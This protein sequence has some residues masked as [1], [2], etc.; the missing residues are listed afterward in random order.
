[1]SLTSTLIP[2]RVLSM[3][4]TIECQGRQDI[5][6]LGH[7]T[8]IVG[9]VPLGLCVLSRQ[10]VVADLVHM[11]VRTAL[12]LILAGEYRGRFGLPARHLFGRSNI[13]MTCL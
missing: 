1:M 11:V 7:C 10:A 9:L 8:H 12:Q 13:S 3:Q 4:S 6:A 2:S 5:H